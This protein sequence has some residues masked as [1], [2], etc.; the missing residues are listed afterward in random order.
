[1]AIERAEDGQLVCK[2]CG[3]TW[4]ADDTV[5][6]LLEELEA[7]SEEHIEH[8]EADTATPRIWLR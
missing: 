8:Q 6:A 1:M 4:T 5:A 3:R 7:H 2:V